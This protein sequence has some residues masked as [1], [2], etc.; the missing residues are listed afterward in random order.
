LFV[1][2]FGFLVDFWYK[3][4]THKFIYF[5]N[6]IIILFYVIMKCEVKKKDTAFLTEKK[7]YQTMSELL[8]FERKKSLF[9]SINFRV[10]L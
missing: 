9:I 5:F 10:F 3:K 6:F 2:I 8:N 7:I 4:Y 1:N